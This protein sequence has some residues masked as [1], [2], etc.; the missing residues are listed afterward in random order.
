[1]LNAL[2]KVYADKGLHVDVAIDERLRFRGDDGDLTEM[3]GNVLDNAFKW[4]RSKVRVRAN[5]TDSALALSIE[6]DGNGIAES[7]AQRVLQRGVRADQS[8]PGHGIGLAVTRDIAE[9]YDGRVMIER[10]AL[11]GAAIRLI[12]P[13]IG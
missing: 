6:D 11:G 13:G 12:L 10:S 5:L 8:T 1:V 7:D 9:A 3:L 2:A 4:A